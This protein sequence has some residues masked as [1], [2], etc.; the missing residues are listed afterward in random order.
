V[1]SPPIAA[2][3]KQSVKIGIAFCFLAVGGALAK[4]TTFANHGL[5]MDTYVVLDVSGKTAKGT[6]RSAA[7][8]SDEKH[9]PTAFTG[10]V[11]ATPK[12]KKG[13]Y[14][15]IHFDGEAPYNTKN[16]LPLTWHLKIVDHRAH[17]FIPVHQR[18]YEG[19]TPRW[20]CPRWS[21]NRRAA[22]EV[23]ARNGAPGRAR[24]FSL[25]CARV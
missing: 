18:N 16:L 7:N 1:D 14:L 20:R 21:W 5:S 13:I 15:E 2:H 23:I 12:G 10:K 17:L 22:T 25:R 24:V 4:E 6:F 3:E 9:G 8:N 19:R 11:I